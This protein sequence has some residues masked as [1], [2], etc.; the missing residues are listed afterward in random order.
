[1]LSAC[2]QWTVEEKWRKR[3]VG[4]Q[5]KRWRRKKRT[6]ERRWQMC[7]SSEGWFKVMGYLK[8]GNEK[9]RRRRMWRT[10]ASNLLWH[11]HHSTSSGLR[12]KTMGSLQGDWGGTTTAPDPVREKPRHSRRLTGK[13]KCGTRVNSGQTEAWKQI[14]PVPLWVREDVVNTQESYS[15]FYD[16]EKKEKPWAI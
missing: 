5:N 15:K 7:S 2:W 14:W 13:G 6:S 8:A 4:I 9:R 10:F 3:D 11:M 12:L 1:M 16:D